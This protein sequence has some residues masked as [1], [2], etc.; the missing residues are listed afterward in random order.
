[1]YDHFPGITTLNDLKRKDKRRSLMYYPLYRAAVVWAMDGTKGFK[2]W[3][4]S[5][6]A[7]VAGGDMS[8]VGEVARNHD[9]STGEST[10]VT[11]TSVSGDASRETKQRLLIH[12]AASAHVQARTSL[13]APDVGAASTVVASSA[14]VV[15]AD[16]FAAYTAQVEER[17]MTRQRDE[18]EAVDKERRE[19]RSQFLAILKEQQT[20]AQSTTK[21]ILE[22]QRVQGAAMTA[23]L[24]TVTRS[25][26]EA[27]DDLIAA[28]RAVVALRRQNSVLEEEKT[29]LGRDRDRVRAVLVQDPARLA[30]I[31]AHEGGASQMRLGTATRADFPALGTTARRLFDACGEAVVRGVEAETPVA[32]AMAPVSPEAEPQGG[33]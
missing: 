21:T 13:E 9:L 16:M 18:R 10:L 7:R 5:T 23:Q 28:Q 27:A 11:A 29:A 12:H 20:T 30:S 1:L 33:P 8:L 24:Q 2:R 26:Q 14:G 25:Y 22:E 32:A 17:A 3:V 4:V 31:F 15:T 19:E 6:T